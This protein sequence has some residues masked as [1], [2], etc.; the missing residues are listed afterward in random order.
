MISGSVS[1]LPL[2]D[3]EVHN[4]VWTF[5]S[6]IVSGLQQVGCFPGRGHADR[7]EY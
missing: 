4:V 2:S 3:I 7:P 5:H 1:F 6:L